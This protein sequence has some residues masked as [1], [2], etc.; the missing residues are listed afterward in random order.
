MRT[1]DQL[2]GPRRARSSRTGA[3]PNIE[4]HA[5]KT[6]KSRKQTS[7]ST[8]NRPAKR[9]AASKVE[10]KKI[11]SL[12]EHEAKAKRKHKGAASAANVGP[13]CEKPA[14]RAGAATSA[15]GRPTGERDAKGAKR[16]SGLDA[17]AQVLADAGGLLSTK[18]MVERMLEK[19]LWRITGKTPAATIYS[20]LLRHIQKN[21]TNSRFRKV[22][23]GR[24]ELVK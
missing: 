23:R 3:G 14:K 11:M 4:E 17:A 13:G 9:L 18:E 10:R 12:A 8:E 6:K 16:M 20:A 2:P 5:V 22:D 24:F 1:D 15:E 19:G 21:G 7:G